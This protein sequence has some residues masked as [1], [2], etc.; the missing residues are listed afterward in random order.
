ME[1]DVLRLR[2]LAGAPSG[3]SILH[4]RI[5]GLESIPSCPLLRLTLHRCFESVRLLI[6]FSL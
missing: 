6:I 1:S 2:P 5:D 4:C 3:I